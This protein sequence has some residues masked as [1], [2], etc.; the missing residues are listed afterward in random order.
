VTSSGTVIG[1]QLMIRTSL[2]EDLAALPTIIDP[3]MP[4]PTMPEDED[5][6]FTEEE[7]VLYVPVRG[8]RLIVIAAE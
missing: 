2:S 1:I 4:I 6:A 5:S 3:T 8:T 7:R